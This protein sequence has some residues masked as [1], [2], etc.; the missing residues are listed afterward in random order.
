MTTMPGRA[1]SGPPTTCLADSGGLPG[2]L[3]D[4]LAGGLPGAV[5]AA[6]AA[7]IAALARARTM[8]RP[9][10]APA[11]RRKRELTVLRSY[12]WRARPVRTA[13]CS[14]RAAYVLVDLVVSLSV[15]LPA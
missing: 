13:A 15:T 2:G 14:I 5:G 7:G 9:A 3:A 8:T 4:G 10:R 1:R 6:L 12:R 11:G